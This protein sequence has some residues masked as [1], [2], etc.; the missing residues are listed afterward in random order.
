MNKAVK[1]RAAPTELS[2]FV[3]QTEAGRKSLFSLTARITPAIARQMLE[4]NDGNRKPNQRTIAAIVEDIRAGRWQVNGESIIF[5]QDGLL[6]DGQNRLLAAV[7]ARKTIESVVV[8]GAP[9]R[10]RFT[11]DMGKGRTAGMILELHHAQSHAR[12][13]SVSQLHLAFL[14]SDYSA[15]RVT[16]AEIVE[17]A[18]EIKDEALIVLNLLAG[19]RLKTPVKTAAA[20]AFML[21]RVVSTVKA[22]EFM[23]GFLHGAGLPKGS[24]VLMLRNRLLIVGMDAEARR[25]PWHMLELFIH[26]WNK[27]RQGEIIAEPYKLTLTYPALV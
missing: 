13:A 21:F 6:N 22:D 7:E 11:V 1:L 10:S 14:H 27:W 16:R 12:L 9:R 20:V 23:E 5:S 18:L 25:R 15:V 3:Q 8:F 2:W 26:H 4:V 19:E 24:P 17:H